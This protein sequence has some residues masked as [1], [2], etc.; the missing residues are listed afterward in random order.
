MLRI[1]YRYERQEKRKKD[2]SASFPVVFLSSSSSEKAEADITNSIYTIYIY[3]FS[4][5]IH[6]QSTYNDIDLFFL[7]S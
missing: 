1:D 6:Y 3:L 5:E 7:L 4:Q 2:A